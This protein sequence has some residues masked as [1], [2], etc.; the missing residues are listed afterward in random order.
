MLQKGVK[1]ELI[2]ESVEGLKSLGFP[3]NGNKHVERY[4]QF[5]VTIL[6]EKEKLSKFEQYVKEL[7]E[8]LQSM[9]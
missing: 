9:N 4:P 5:D 1:K 7:K 6:N 2:Q 3:L 8:K